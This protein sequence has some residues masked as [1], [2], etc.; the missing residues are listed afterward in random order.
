M[1]L[2]ELADPASRPVF[3]AFGFPDDRPAAGA[4]AQMHCLDN[5]STTRALLDLLDHI[6]RVALAQHVL[7]FQFQHFATKLL[8]TLLQLAGQF[9]V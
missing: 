6:K 5:I 1:I 4:G 2:L 7:D 9:L 3:G 8:G